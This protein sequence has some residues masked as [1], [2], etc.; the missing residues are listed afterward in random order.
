[1]SNSC[2]VDSELWT[3]ATKSDAIVLWDFNVRL[4]A[5]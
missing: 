1:M 2:P 5:A 3:I 4:I